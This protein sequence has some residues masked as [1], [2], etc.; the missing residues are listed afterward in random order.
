M[1]ADVLT[2]PLQGGLFVSLS[3]ALMRGA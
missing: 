3:A 2:K 1:V